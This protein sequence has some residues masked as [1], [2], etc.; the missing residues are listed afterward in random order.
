MLNIKSEFDGL[1]MVVS[2]TW[3]TLPYLTPTE[4][5]REQGFFVLDQLPSI[6]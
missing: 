2:S 1:K 4:T 3:S 5:N 6:F